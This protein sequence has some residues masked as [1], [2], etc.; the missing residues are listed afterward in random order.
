[1]SESKPNIQSDGS[2]DALKNFQLTTAGITDKS[3]KEYGLAI[4]KYIASTTSFNVGGYYFNRNARFIK[5]RNYANGRIDIQAMFQ[6]RFQFNG[7]QN[8]IA[9]NWN[10][11]Q[12]VNRIV[13]GLVG[14]WMKRGEKIQV[15]AIDDLSQTQKKEEYEQIEFAIENREMLEKLEAESGVQIL[16]QDE[17]LPR[18]KEQLNIWKANFQKTPEEIQN[19][20]GCNDI[21]SSNGMFDVQKEKLLHDAAEVLFVGTYTYMDNEGVVHV[22]VVKPENAI[23]SYSEQ[24]DLRDTTWRGEAPSI[25]ISELRKQWGKEFN[26]NNPFALTE[27]QLWKIAQS[28]KE[29]QYYSNILAWNE[30][31]CTTFLRPYDEWNIRSIQIE[32]KTVDS[33]PYTVTKSKSTG[34]TY[35]QKG[36][37]V[38]K[39][40]KKRDQP[41]ENQNIINDTNWN[42]YRGVYLPDSDVL[43]EWG[44]KDNMI[45]PQDPKEIGNAEFSYSFVM[46]QN[47]LMRNLAIP[48]KIEAAVDGMILALLKMQQVVA[49]MR[50]TGAAIDESALANID[51]GLGESGNRE[52][53]YKK[54]YDQTGDIYYRSLD[55]EGNRVP[56][57]I[58]E[59]QNSGFL[60]QM[61][62]LIKNYQFNYQILKDEL[63]EDPNL[64]SSALQPRVTAGNVEASQLQAEYAT[65]YIYRAYS[66]CMKITARKI[67]CLLKD[68]ITYGAKAYR[69]IVKQEAVMGRQFTTD[70]KFLPTEQDILRF[71]AM[72]N[73]AMMATP[74]LN[75]FINPFQLMQMAKEDVKLAWLYFNQ[76]Q[77]KMILHQQETAAQNQQAT[78]EGQ[79]K[80]AQAAEE[81]KQQTETIKG[82][83][84][85]K[86]TQLN[87]E[88]QNRTSVIN[89]V[90]SWLAPSA[91]GT[92]GKVPPEYQPLVQA[93]IQ[94][95]MISSIAATEEQKQQ[96]IA[97]MQEAQMQQQQEQQMAMQAQQGQQ[98][99]QPQQP[100][101]AA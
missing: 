38:T 18:D 75:L 98:D 64:V 73:Q 28:A 71:E 57:P 90:T 46:P 83:I 3:S 6:D 44:L 56:I 17:S 7:K 42:I 62:G 97:K 53:D 63:G 34:T 55:A 86:K 87:G 30:G 84:D 48:E 10:A 91:D 32:V 51:Y 21:L 77:K 40:G 9:L 52:I 16:P 96:I 37:P 68:S 89:M 69:H 24:I 61:D 80:S 15:T 93:V 23:Y 79:I 22:R 76:G 49:R 4:C 27:E 67:S 50:P 54:L 20:M 29:F 35:T 60:G 12:I 41:L 43:L 11:L 59:L 72:M 14:R 45:R 94:N 78:I 31:W 95:I 25:K 8:Y 13:S 101:I 74:E 19:E 1:M 99:Q 58:V 70:I 33:E 92:I 26:P 39:S 65:D 82:D 81:A 100:Q 5:N 88:A 85:I 36:Y 66:E 47:Y 2:G